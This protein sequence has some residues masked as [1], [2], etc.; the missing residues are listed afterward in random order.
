MGNI[1]NFTQET[2]NGRWFRTRNDFKEVLQNA[3]RIADVIESSF[4]N[5]ED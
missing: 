1:Y 3:I 4:H 2:R 5:N